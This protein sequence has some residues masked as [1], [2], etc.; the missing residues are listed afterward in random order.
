MR[1]RRA[2]NPFLLRA[3]REAAGMTQE[4]LGMAIGHK[5]ASARKVISALESGRTRMP[6]MSTTRRVAEALGVPPDDLICP[7]DV[8]FE[9]EAAFLEWRAE[10]P[11][12]SLLQWIGDRVGGK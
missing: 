2:F 6:Y 5:Q 1:H 7:W 3:Y 12:C 8:W 9:Y 10:D 11:D 4:E